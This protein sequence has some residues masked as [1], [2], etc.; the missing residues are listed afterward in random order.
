M[1]TIAAMLQVQH[2]F[3]QPSK[4]KAAAV[5]SHTS[6]Y[7]TVMYSPSSLLPSILP[8]SLPSFLPP[9]LPLPPSPPAQ[10]KARRMFCVYEGDHL[11]LLNVYKAFIRV[12]SLSPSP[13]LSLSPSLFL[14]LSLFLS[15]SLPPLFLPLSLP[16]PLPLPLPLSLPPPLSLL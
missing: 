9:S 8:P 11:T 13:S 7:G 3:L 4:M 2:I 6:V 15:P 1:L 12:R 5:S 14:S 10:E 16:P